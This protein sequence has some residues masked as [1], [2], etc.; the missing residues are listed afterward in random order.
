MTTRWKGTGFGTVLADF[1]HDG[2]L[3]LAVVNGNVQAGKLV[4]DKQINPA[5]F[6]DDY[7]ERNQLFLNN[8]HGTFLDVS[9]ANEAFCGTPAVAR[10]LTW[11]DF[12]GDGAVDLLVTTVAGPA[13]LYRNVAAKKGHWLM[14]RAV[15]PTLGGRDAYGAEVV[16]EAGKRTWLGW[17]NPGTSYLCSNDPRAH[18]GLGA[19]EQVD[20]IHVTWP[21]GMRETF[22]AP[23]IDR[24]L[25]LRKGEGRNA[26][27]LEVRDREQPGTR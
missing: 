14:V 22:A 10:G 3:D 1:D 4:K 26:T 20:A 18:F 11:L 13:R 16:V 15:D 19:V 25:L 7:V 12:D 6:W 5:T 9:P 8:G 27:R 24:V 2:H 23:A 21:D 17:I